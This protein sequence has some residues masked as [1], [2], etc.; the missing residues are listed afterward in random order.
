MFCIRCLHIDNRRLAHCPNC[1]GS[2]FG[3]ASGDGFVT[4][5]PHESGMPCQACLSLN[6][7]LRFRYFKH[8]IGMI[9]ADR[10]AGVA[11]Y[12]CPSCVKGQFARQMSLTLVLGWWGILAAFF[13]NPLAILTNVWGLFA[14]PLNA[15]DYGAIHVNALR[16]SAAQDI[17]DVEEVPDW[18]AL[19]QSELEM[20][21]SR[22]DYY[23]ALRVSSS[24][25]SEEIKSAWRASVKRL[26]PDSADNT[27]SAGSDEHLLE[28]NNAYQ[29]LR[30]PRLREAYDPAR[31]LI[32]ETP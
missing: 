2:A 29:V 13:R 15:G 21:L 30:D 6:G 24:A 11:G 9:L 31:E 10:I 27:V 26:H 8:V 12:F 23:A 16:A 17:A 5:I 1:A 19:S 28:V 32:H 3:S 4:R 25:T 22:T 18:L 14:A 7:E 20:V